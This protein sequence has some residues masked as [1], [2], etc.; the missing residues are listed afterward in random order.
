MSLKVLFLVNSNLSILF[1]ENINKKC[2]DTFI[3]VIVKGPI[4]VKLTL[5][6]LRFRLSPNW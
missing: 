3:F 4:Y 5:L 6:A 1:W 2:N